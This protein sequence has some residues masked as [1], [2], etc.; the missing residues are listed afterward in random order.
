METTTAAGTRGGGGTPYV[1]GLRAAGGAWRSVAAVAAAVAAFVLTVFVAMPPLGR[2]LDGLAGTGPFDPADP[3]VTPGL[4]LAGNLLLAALIPV[5]GL[6]QWAVFGVRPG[7]LSSVAGGFR[8]G[9]FAR[10]ALVVVPVWL[11]FLTGWYALNP[12][13]T[14]VFTAGTL[15]LVALALVT[16]PLQSA[17]EEYLFRGLVQRSVGARWA[18][19]TAAFAVSTAFSAVLFA[20]VHGSADPWALGY[21][22]ASG[23]GMSLM[24]RFSGGLEAAVLVHGVHNTLLLVPVLLAGALGSLAVT[25]GP[26]MAVPAALMLVFPFAVRALARRYG[27]AVAEAG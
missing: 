13:G 14:P 20:A 17:G 24:T 2:L 10:L 19:T 26:V 21:Y 9:W 22:L 15:A 16:V 1:Q 11:V 7:R 4:W 18:G 5:S 6:V 8:W 27:T 12:A 25:T 3:S 23:V